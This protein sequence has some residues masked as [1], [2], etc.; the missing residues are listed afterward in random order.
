MVN[1]VV[2]GLLAVTVAGCGTQTRVVRRTAQADIANLGWDLRSVNDDLL[3][4]RLDLREQRRHFQLARHDLQVVRQSSTGL[5]CE[6]AKDVT[7]DARNARDGVVALHN[8]AG[9]VRGSL[10]IVRLD[11]FKL[12]RQRK[13]PRPPSKSARQIEHA[14]IEADRTVRVYGA[15]ASSLTSEAQRLQ[16]Q[17]ARMAKLAATLCKRARET[18]GGP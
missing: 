13:T 15:Q 4:A 7:R 12:A 1:V 17:T 14:R 18:A 3:V 6:A 8:D 10:R 9:R 5:V 11:L 2:V 16:E